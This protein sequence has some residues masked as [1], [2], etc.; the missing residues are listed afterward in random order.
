MIRTAVFLAASLVFVTSA[1]TADKPKESPAALERKLHGEWIGGPCDG[2]LVL[3]A[4][5]SF[6]RRRYTPGDNKLTGSWELRWNALPP[7]LV[8]ACRT[9]DD[10]DFVGK[11][12]EVR[13]IQMD[14]EAIAYQYAG[15][16]QVIRYERVKRADKPKEGPAALERRLHGTWNGPPCT[17]RLTLGADGT[18]ERRNYSPGNYRLTGT[19]EV[20]WNALPPTLVL[21][22]KTS[23]CP[24]FVGKTSEVKLVQLDD[25]VLALGNRYEDRYER[26]K[27][28]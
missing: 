22:C 5:G 18:F 13:L 3:G 19:W 6:E 8:L 26:V 11:T 15:N 25:E 4:D 28:K 1:R 12:S 9:S 2:E 10:P 27:K 24:G 21:A 16:E 20:R 23:D 7:T 14:D 17:G